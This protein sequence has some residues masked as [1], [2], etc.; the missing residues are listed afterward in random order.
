MSAIRNLGTLYKNILQF[1]IALIAQHSALCYRGGET[2]LV[3]GADFKSV[4]RFRENASVGFD[5]HT[6]PP[7]PS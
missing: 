5:S 7:I 1:I 3:I 2:G 6:P 4:G